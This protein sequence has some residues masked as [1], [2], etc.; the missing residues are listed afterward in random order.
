MLFIIPFT[1][2]Q[3]TIAGLRPCESYDSWNR[4]VGLDIDPYVGSPT[5]AR[6]DP[7]MPALSGPGSKSHIELKTEK[8]ENQQQVKIRKDYRARTIFC[9]SEKA[10]AFNL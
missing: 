1:Q 7:G 6:T 9:T 8:P 3:S 2:H 4:L 10:P 5:W